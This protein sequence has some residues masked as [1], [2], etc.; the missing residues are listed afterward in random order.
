MSEYAH[1]RAALDPLG[2][3]YLED[4]SRLLE[5][6]LVLSDDPDCDPPSTLLDPVCALDST[7]A[8]E[9]AHTLLDLADHADRRGQRGATR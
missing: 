4:G 5:I 9:L 2:T 3:V 1:A 7:R 8:R 6:A